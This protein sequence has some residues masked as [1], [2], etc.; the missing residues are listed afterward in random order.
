MSWVKKLKYILPIAFLLPLS[1]LINISGNDANE[2]NKTEETAKEFIS[3]KDA[4]QFVELYRNEKYIYSYK[5]SLDIIQVQDIN[6]KEVLW[7][8]G[9]DV[10]YY[11]NKT[12][13]VN[14]CKAGLAD[15]PNFKCDMYENTTGNSIINSLVTAYAYK[16]GDDSFSTAFSL[17]SADERDRNSSTLKRINNSK[18]HYRLD[19]QF[20]YNVDIDLSLHIYFTD[21]GI[22][23]EIRHDEITGPDRL[24]LVDVTIAPFI[25]ATGGAAQEFNYET[26]KYD[27]DVIQ[28]E[29]ANGYIVVPDGSGSLIPFKNN[30]VALGTYQSYVYGQNYSNLSHHY[31]PESNQTIVPLKDASMPM[32]GVVHNKTDKNSQKAVLAY[33][34]KGEEFMSINVSPDL[35]DNDEYVYVYAKFNKNFTYTEYYS[36]DLSSRATVL[37]QKPFDYDIGMKYEFLEGEDANYV[38][39]ANAYRNH[40]INEEKKLALNPSTENHITTRLDFIMADAEDSVLGTTDAIVTTANDVKDILNDALDNGVDNIVTSLLG[41]Q[42]GGITLGDPSDVDFSSSIGTAKEYRSLISNMEDKGVDVS[43]SQDYYLINDAQIS[44][45]GNAVKHYNGKYVEYHS[46]NHSFISDFNYARADKAAKWMK[47]Q[48]AEL[49]SET[50]VNSMTVTGISNNVL[51]NSTGSRKAAMNN[52]ENAFSYLKEKGKVNADQPNSYLW[53]Y[54]D[55][56]FNIPVTDSQHLIEEEEIP[57]LQLVLRGCMELYAPYSNFSFYNQD[58]I[59]KMIDFNVYPSFVLSKESSH[60][61]S[62]TNSAN[63]YS[64]EYSL[65]KDLIKNVY[66]QVD[67]ALGQVISADWISRQKLDNGLIIN[68]YS[69]G[70]K[71]V[72]NYSN[73]P[74]PY[75]GSVSIPA[76]GFEVL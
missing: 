56:Y 18:D 66:S 25:G 67:S 6:T 62:Y 68:E 32:F 75:S 15:D 20:D 38:G 11:R 1:S 2:G 63:Y 21:T 41:W 13:A 49:R 29:M 23:F 76:Q 35:A 58:S 60:Y 52:I 5:E 36:Q 24:N 71:I 64:T 3:E 39:I 46:F 70:K 31:S 55:R 48:N 30:N 44:L 12:A 50:G 16:H 73:K 74:L 54:I 4:K 43:F 61:L 51:S 40:L 17:S 27:G 28:K 22:E 47:S 69:N 8:T 9:A 7:K 10:N 72:I 37:N 19:V 33:A 14:A 26:M 53:K 65:Y 57:L 34:T 45:R 42:S 59:L